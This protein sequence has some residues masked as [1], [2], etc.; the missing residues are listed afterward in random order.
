MPEARL[1]ANSSASSL[2]NVA[3]RSVSSLMGLQLVSRLFTFALNQALVRIASPQ[4][5]GTASIQFELVLSTILFLS[6]EGVRNSLLRVDGDS[7]SS[8]NSDEETRI[9]AIQTSNL[10]LL[11]FYSGLPISGLVA[12]IYLYFSSMETREQPYFVLSIAVYV[13][14]ATIEL[15][16]EPLHTRTMQ[17]LNSALRFRAEGLGVVSKTAIT[18]IVLWYDSG[19][20][21]TPPSFGLTAFALGQLT[22]SAMVFCVYA[23]EYGMSVKHSP[24]SKT[25]AA[26]KQTRISFFDDKLVT[27]AVAMTGQSVVKHFLTEGDKLVISKFSPLKDQGGYAIA[28]NYGS[29]VA[30]ILL[31]PIEETSRFF[32]SR[33]L[34]ST[35][36]SHTALVSASTTLN[37]LLLFY[38][39]MALFLVSLARP[40]LS[41]VFTAL[42]PQRYLST[43]APSI[44]AAWIWYIPVLAVNGVLEA[45]VSSIATVSDVRSQSKWMTAFSLLYLVATV[46]L[47]KAA[48]IGDSA[49]VYANMVNLSA[50]IIYCVRVV[51]V[52]FKRHIP[53]NKSEGGSSTTPWK[54][55]IP[56]YPVLTYFA[57]AWS[58]TRAS[59]QIF[60]VEHVVGTL[61]KRGLLSSAIVAH[62]AVGAVAGILGLVV[63]LV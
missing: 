29:L 48:G 5:F 33:T 45:F 24:D 14:A 22:Y 4:T 59:N 11:P 50:R 44:L 25:T 32:F 12:G 19:R 53:Q 20:R 8:K 1:P 21:S 46:V 10:A 27:V 58:V 35:S 9:R 16:C 38:S 39:H 40:Y 56:P 23:S 42:L 60:K 3:L 54:D 34:S 26:A 61:G 63:W 36:P 30:R 18:F 55:C 47:Y 51:D 49:L 41:I 62:C 57:V 37:S 6:R 13:L 17:Q 2:R 7:T 31:Q 43:S 15:L 28:V 52:Y